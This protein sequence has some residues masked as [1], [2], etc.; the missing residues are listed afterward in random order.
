MRL[1]L[2]SFNERDSFFWMDKGINMFLSIPRFCRKVSINE[3]C[4]T[5]NGFE[6][7][8]FTLEINIDVKHLLIS[9]ILILSWMTWNNCFP[10]RCII[11]RG[12]IL[13]F[14]ELRTYSFS[15]S[16]H[17]IWIT[18]TLC[19]VES[20][21]TKSIFAIIWLSV[22]I[23]PV[24]TKIFLVLF[25]SIRRGIFFVSAKIQNFGIILCTHSC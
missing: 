21:I 1:N 14:R 2:R 11:I 25:E 4:E 22:Y 23:H 7:K 15:T 18:P 24:A 6:W 19:E 10:L 16:S 13:H 5:S 12:W 9:L 3:R 17:T 8:R 20:V